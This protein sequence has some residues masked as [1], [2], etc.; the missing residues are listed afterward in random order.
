MACVLIWPPL[1]VYKEDLVVYPENGWSL[2]GLSEAYH[3]QF[4][5][6]QV[7]KLKPRYEKVWK[8][9]DVQ[10]E[11]SCIQFSKPWGEV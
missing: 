10:I 2:H 5:F 11:S 1:Q 3:R 6:V 8:A 9:A 7:D 4:N